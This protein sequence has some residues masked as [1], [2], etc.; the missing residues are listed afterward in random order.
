MLKES[1]R[2]FGIAD[3]EMNI[4]ILQ[5]VTIFEISGATVFVIELK[6]IKSV[7]GDNKF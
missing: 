4:I 2:K 7:I 3:F 6:I 1:F 5:M